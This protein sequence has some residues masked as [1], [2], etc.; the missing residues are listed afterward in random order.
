MAIAK[1]VS[2]RKDAKSSSKKLAEYIADLEKTGTKTGGAVYYENLVFK[3]AIDAAKEIESVVIMSKRCKDPLKHLVLSFKAEKLTNEQVHEAV[4][5]FLNELGFKDNQAIIAVHRNT[6]NL[7]A[8]I[9]LNRVYYNIEKDKFLAKKIDFFKSAMHLAARKMEIKHSLNHDKGIYE[10]A[11]NKA[12]EKEII[13]NLKFPYQPREARLERD[14]KYEK[15]DKANFHYSNRAANKSGLTEKM[16]AQG[17][18]SFKGFLIENVSTKV[19]EHLANDRASWQSL[20]ELLAKNDAMLLPVKNGMRLV[21]LSD[22]KTMAKASD[23]YSGFSKSKLEKKLGSFVEHDI[24]HIRSEIK[25]SKNVLPGQHRINADSENIEDTKLE[26]FVQYVRQ[27]EVRNPILEALKKDKVTWLSLHQKL[28]DYDIMIIPGRNGLRIEPINKLDVSTKASSIHHSL[29]KAKLE[30]KLG[31]YE[32]FTPSTRKRKNPNENMTKYIEKKFKQEEIQNIQTNKN[33]KDIRDQKKLFAQYENEKQNHYKQN[34]M[35]RRFLKGQQ[36]KGEKDRWSDFLAERRA[37]LKAR[38]AAAPRGTKKLERSLHAA[39]TAGLKDRMKEQRAAERAKNKSKTD[40]RFPTWRDWLQKQ[41]SPA[42]KKSYSAM[43]KREGEKLVNVI[44]NEHNSTAPVAT[45]SYKEF[46]KK[47]DKD[48]TKSKIF[49]LVSHKVNERNLTIDYYVNDLKEDDGQK[50][51]PADF[52]DSGAAITFNKKLSLKKDTV[53][54]AI[55]IAAEKFNNNIHIS[56][57]ENFKREAIILAVKHNIKISNSEPE[58]VSYY[59]EKVEENKPAWVRHNES[60]A[61]R[62]EA[63]N[64]GGIENKRDLDLEQ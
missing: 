48:N 41:N 33:N 19:K 8:H 30:K 6:D 18:Q 31:S 29:T 13:R 11:I 44:R 22:S 57:S 49:E 27:D 42:A 9:E 17:L 1:D 45:M 62:D 20:Q 5:T 46:K 28:E 59:N 35:D 43:Q 53:E 2:K 54:A 4:K 47:Y 61:K 24:K 3:N 36:G 7:H 21:C 51:K 63:E 58:L 52:V 25:Y 60:I 26:A 23:L 14:E 16:E 32:S 15:E 39:E 40:T 64:T 55:L 50:E 10:V 12:G 34:A 38:L 56:G 37:T